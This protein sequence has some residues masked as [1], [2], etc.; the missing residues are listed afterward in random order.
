MCV[1]AQEVGRYAVDVRMCSC[2]GRDIKA[3][4]GKMQPAVT[5]AATIPIYLPT[6]S[7]TKTKSKKRKPTATQAAPAPP[8]TSSNAPVDDDDQIYTVQVIE[9]KK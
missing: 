1:R 9:M 4:E 3:E 6:E 8:P 7:F 5:P 2:P